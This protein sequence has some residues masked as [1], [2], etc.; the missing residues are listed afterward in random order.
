MEMGGKPFFC[1]E[2]LS[3]LKTGNHGRTVHSLPGARCTKISKE[4]S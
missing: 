2:K 4:L 1:T 3:A